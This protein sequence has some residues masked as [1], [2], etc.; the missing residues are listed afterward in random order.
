MRNVQI[1]VLCYQQSQL[2][3][4]KLFHGSANNTSW[5]STFNEKYATNHA[6]RCA[7]VGVFSMVYLSMILI[8]F[9]RCYCHVVATQFSIISP[10]FSDKFMVHLAQTSRVFQ[11]KQQRVFFRR[12]V[13]NICVA[14]FYS[15]N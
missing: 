7:F 14:S 6:L 13:A 5:K 1:A 11:S 9:N 15:S 4:L 3:C 10:D 8:F 2:R 12:A